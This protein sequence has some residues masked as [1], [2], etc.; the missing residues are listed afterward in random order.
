[1]T[2]CIMLS[3]KYSLKCCTCLNLFEF[4]SRIQNPIEK[5]RKGIRKSRE[6]EKGKA[7]QLGLARPRAR[8]PASPD[9]RA[10]PVIDCFLSRALSLSPSARWGQH[11]GAS[12]FAPRA[13]LFSLCLVG[14]FCQALSLCPRAPFL[15]LCAVDPPYQFRPHCLRRGP[16]RAHS[17]TSPEFLATTPTHAHLAPS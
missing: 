15:S 8:A 17:R 5:N 10:P 11:V 12:C 3:L 13:S 6:K 7:A 9:R 16:A 1:M 2:C 14:P 4:E